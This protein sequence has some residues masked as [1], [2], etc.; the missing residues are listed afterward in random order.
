MAVHR[1]FPPIS[2]DVLE[3][4]ARILGPSSA[5]AQ[6]LADADSHNGVSNFFKL[7]NTIIVQKVDADE[8][9]PS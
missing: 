9:T 5:A 1:N 3:A 7:G 4:T 6:A 2:R 8:V